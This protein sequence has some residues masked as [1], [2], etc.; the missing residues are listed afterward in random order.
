MEMIMAV[1]VTPMPEEDH[2]RMSKLTLSACM[3]K[4]QLK[5]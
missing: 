3:K 4:S 2:T 5:I 1:R